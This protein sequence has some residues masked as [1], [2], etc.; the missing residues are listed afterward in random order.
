M[1]LP[2]VRQLDIMRWLEAGSCLKSSHYSDHSDRQRDSMRSCYRIYPARSALS[3]VT[4]GLVDKMKLRG[5]VESFTPH[6]AP[7]GSYYR[8]TDAGRAAVIESIRQH[9]RGRADSKPKRTGRHRHLSNHRTRVN[10][11]RR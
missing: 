9:E 11:V 4:I 6:Q 7:A 10:R 8:I 1:K 5:W 3:I 2:T